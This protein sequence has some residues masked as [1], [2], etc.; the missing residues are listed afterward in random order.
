MNPLLKNWQT[1][2]AG[3]LA[4]LATVETVGWT[5]PDGT[6]NWSAIFLGCALAVLGAV[7]KQHNVTGGTVAVTPEAEERVETNPETK[8][9]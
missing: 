2:L 8:T 4:G 6:P 9:T 5:K 3:V 1:T 7:S